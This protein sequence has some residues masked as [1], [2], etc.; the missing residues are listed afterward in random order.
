[1]P[2]VAPGLFVASILTSQRSWDIALVHHPCSQQLQGARGASPGRL[3]V[4]DPFRGAT[5]PH[6]YAKRTDLCS[7]RHDAPVRSGAH[8]GDRGAVDRLHARMQARG[9]WKREDQRIKQELAVRERLARKAGRLPSS[10]VATSGAGVPS[11]SAAVK[12]RKA[13]GPPSGEAAAAA[14][15]RV[16]ALAG[17]AAGAGKKEQKLVDDVAKVVDRMLA[18]V[19]KAVLAEVR[20][21][22]KSGLFLRCL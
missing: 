19:E 8:S 12:K 9:G 7:T 17:V 4:A 13:E 11:F 15:K 2:A 5:V 1:M 21:L 3:G 16:R 10:Q 20:V 6:G 14:L 18:K 22:L